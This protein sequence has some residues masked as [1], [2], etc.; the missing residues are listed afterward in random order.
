MGRARR[1]GDRV[2]ALDA[3]I[4]LFAH[5]TRRAYS[6]LVA[7]VRLLA[8]SGRWYVD[9]SLSFVHDRRDVPDYLAR[10]LYSSLVV[11]DLVRDGGVTLV[12]LLTDERHAGHRDALAMSVTFDGNEAKQLVYDRF[13]TQDGDDVV[14]VVPRGNAGQHFALTV[15]TTYGDVWLRARGYELTQG[16][17][18]NDVTYMNM[19]LGEVHDIHPLPTHETHYV[20]VM[21]ERTRRSHGEEGSRGYEYTVPVRVGR[22]HDMQSD[23]VAGIIERNNR[24]RTTDEPNEHGRT[25]VISAPG[26]FALLEGK[27]EVL[28]GQAEVLKQLNDEL[29]RQIQRQ[30]T[31]QGAAQNRSNRETAK[32]G[33]SPDTRSRLWMLIDVLLIRDRLVKAA[34][35]V[36]ATKSYSSWRPWPS[37]AAEQGD[38][39]LPLLGRASELARHIR[40]GLNLEE[41]NVTLSIADADASVVCKSRPSD[42]SEWNVLTVVNLVVIYHHAMLHPSDDECRNKLGEEALRGERISTRERENERA[43]VVNRCM[44]SESQRLTDAKADEVAKDLKDIIEEVHKQLITFETT[45]NPKNTRFGESNSRA[46]A[47]CD[48]VPCLVDTAS[49]VNALN[50]LDAHVGGRV[51]CEYFTG[52]MYPATLSLPTLTSNNTRSMRDIDVSVLASRGRD[53]DAFCVVIKVADAMDFVQKTMKYVNVT[54]RPLMRLST[55]V[56]VESPLVTYL[57]AYTVPKLMAWYTRYRDSKYQHTDVLNLIPA[58]LVVVDAD[59]AAAIDRLQAAKFSCGPRVVRALVDDLCKASDGD[60]RYTRDEARYMVL[61]CVALA[62]QRSEFS[63]APYVELT[64]DRNEIKIDVTE[65]AHQSY[66]VRVAHAWKLASSILATH[67]LYDAFIK[68][69]SPPW[70]AVPRW[71]EWLDADGDTPEKR[72]RQRDFRDKLLSKSYRNQS[73]K[74]NWDGID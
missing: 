8:P 32:V 43:R 35:H 62:Y 63:M 14:V 41:M 7:A 73:I 51:D 40:S 11:C 53:R 12:D 21:R 10:V 66:A 9:T 58:A 25:Y 5:I 54:D 23:G 29:V 47:L 60:A 52:E 74:P 56:V 30:E 24:G 19:V 38:P 65:A 27:A 33:M 49:E 68:T 1:T 37:K 36:A 59:L 2:V 50:G 48:G 55:G 13:Q 3:V 4:R 46:F 17:V 67:G 34:Q 61:A 72:E 26:A 71:M 15:A 39:L 16:R 22:L 28:K 70:Y 57:C 42:C 69:E 18:T 6:Q 20:L 64:D 44:Q 45:T 31:A